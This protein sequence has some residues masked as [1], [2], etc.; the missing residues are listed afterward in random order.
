MTGTSRTSRARSRISAGRQ[1]RLDAVDQRAGGA[2]GDFDLFLE[3]RIA[4]E[5]LEHEAILLRFGK[6]IGPFLLDRIL[7]GQHEERIGKFVPDAAHGD[8]PLLHGFEQRGLGFG[9]GAVQFVGQD[10]VGKEWPFEKTKLAAAGRTILFD[11]LGAGDVGRHQVGGELNAAE[12]KV[13]RPRQG[14]DHQRFGQ[15]GNAFQQAMAAAEERNQQ[16]LDHGV[17]ADDD[18]RQLIEDLLPGLAQFMNGR[19]GYAVIGQGRCASFHVWAR[20]KRWR[21]RLKG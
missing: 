20:S 5:D 12:R 21:N 9:R 17:L 4:D 6:R 13:E 10:D 18:L 11:D 7:R 2:A 8:L 16:L 19:I 15:A 1:H 14:A 3:R